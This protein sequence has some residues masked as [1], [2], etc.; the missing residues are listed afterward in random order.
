[1]GEKWAASGGGVVCSFVGKSLGGRCGWIVCSTN[2]QFIHQATVYSWPPHVI[3]LAASLDQPL[4]FP[5]G[6]W[7]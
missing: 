2:C 5:S 1:V 6:W 4:L 3:T 7:F